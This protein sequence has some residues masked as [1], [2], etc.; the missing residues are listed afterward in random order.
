MKISQTLGFD[1]SEY[2][3]G[4]AQL[5]LTYGATN[6]TGKPDQSQVE[7]ML[8][9]ACRGGITAID[10][11]QAYGD[12]ERVIG[13]AFHNDRLLASRLTVITKLGPLTGL[14]TMM[15]KEIERRVIGS[16]EESCR[17]LGIASLSLVLLHRPV[18]VFY[19]HGLILRLL[20]QLQLQ[21]KI[22]NL[23]VSVYTPEEALACLQ[24]DGLVALQLPFHVLDTRHA[25]AGVFQQCVQKQIAIF[26]RTVFL[27]GLLAERPDHTGSWPLP[28]APHL[29]RFHDIARSMGMSG[30]QLA[31][32]FCRAYG[33][34][35]G[36]VLGAE[37][38]TQVRENLELFKSAPLSRNEAEALAK[39]FA[40]LSEK[41]ISPA[42]WTV[43]KQVL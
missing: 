42:L 8:S 35:S 28:L 41:W 40:G 20:Q 32:A 2:V 13:C 12:S 34:V 29:H 19:M 14:E 30:K 33:E 21:G 6:R 3:M 16:I 25:T 9:V 24:V 26:A 37:T 22:K 17:N 11:A 1:C 27:Q 23:G 15:G 5:G 31:L 36:F 7:D 4:G 10:T 39:T 18:H 38:T 43:T